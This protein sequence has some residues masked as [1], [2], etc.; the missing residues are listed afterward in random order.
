VEALQR[1]SENDLHLLDPYISVYIKRAR[2]KVPTE[3]KFFTF[4]EVTLEED[5]YALARRASFS[6]DMDPLHTQVGQGS[7]IN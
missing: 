3:D 5:Q 4:P 2:V 1:F 6:F 7:R